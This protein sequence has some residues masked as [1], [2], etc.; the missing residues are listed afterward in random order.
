MVLVVHDG[1]MEDRVV[2]AFAAAVAAIGAEPMVMGYRP[3]SFV[4]MQVFG[5]FAAASLAGGRQV[6]AAVVAAMDA[7]DVAV[8]LNADLTPMFDAA[9]LDVARSSTRVGWIPYIGLDDMLRLLPATADEVDELLRRTAAVGEAVGGAT[10]VRVTSP[11]GTDLALRIGQRR[12]NCSAGVHD[13]QRGF[14]GLE[15]LPGG[16]VSTVPDAGTAEGTLVIDRSVNAPE[17]KELLDPIVFTVSGGRVVGVDGGVEAERMERFLA[18]L[19][20]PDVYSLTELGIGSNPR[21]TA[22]GRAGPCE[23]THTLGAVSFALGA[24][25]HL[26]GEVRAPIHL[27]MTLRRPSLTLDGATLVDDGALM[28]A[29]ER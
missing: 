19:N 8:V 26:G 14:G 12:L 20:H 9:F 27:D 23:D 22:A 24:D 15:V 4:S 3:R 2:D 10:D 5:H 25:V 13:P 28:V 17:Y 7:A 1:T 29:T 6:P 11:A 16:Q 21:C 18:G